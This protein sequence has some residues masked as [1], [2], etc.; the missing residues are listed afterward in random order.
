MLVAGCDGSGR[1]RV[2]PTPADSPPPPAAPFV[3]AT[4]ASHIAYRVGYPRP[5]VIVDRRNVKEATFGGAASGDCDGD[6]DIDLFITYGNTGG[7]DGGGGP[8]RL[9]LNQLVER[10]NGLLFEDIAEAA[11]VANDNTAIRWKPYEVKLA[12]TVNTVDSV[13]RQVSLYYNEEIN[14]KGD[15]VGVMDLFVNHWDRK[16]AVQVLVRRECNRFD[17]F[18]WVEWGNRFN[19]GITITS[20]R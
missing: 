2:A 6:R 16:G 12:A 10:G 11:G 7:P 9:Y 17:F 13:Y 20:K 5:A 3:D 1:E 15:S 14:P 8:N 18:D 4:S 19:E